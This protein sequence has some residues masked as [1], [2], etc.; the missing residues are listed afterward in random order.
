MSLLLVLLLAPPVSEDA[1][2]PVE[3]VKEAPTKVVLPEA[4][5]EPEVTKVVLPEAEPEAPEEKAPEEPAEVPA[6]EAAPEPP[7]PCPTYCDQ[8]SV[9]C[10]DVFLGNR[11]TC[12]ATCS[13]YPLDKVDIEA[14]HCRIYGQTSSL[15]IPQQPVE[16]KKKQVGPAQD[17]FF[18]DHPDLRKDRTVV[19]PGMGAV[20]LPPFQ[21]EEQPI[22]HA[23]KGGKLIGEGPLGRRIVL[24]P[25]DYTVH[26]GD[27]ADPVRVKVKVVEG[28]TTIVPEA[29]GGL[30]VDVV[31][32]R[33]VPFRGAYELIR[34]DTHD[35]V[36][37]GFGADALLGE[38]A[39]VW[40]VPPGIYKI[41]QSGGTY[42]DRTNFATVRV[43]SGEMQRFT[44]VMDPDT[45]EFEGAGLND[46]QE[47]DSGAWTF[48]GTI[49]GNVEFIRSELQAEE[50]S[51]QVSGFLD[52]SMRL[53]VGDHRWET[54]VDV[55]ESQ[56][57]NSTTQRFTNLNDRLFSHTIYTY[58]V[59][60]WFGPYVRA[61]FD[62]QILPREQT[63]DD[64][65]VI[66][67][68]EGNAQLTDR[69]LLAGFF[70]PM[71]FQEG[72]GGNVRVW[73]SREAEFYLRIGAGAFQLLPNR[74]RVLREVDGAPDR[75]VDVDADQL[76]GMESTAK[77]WARLF[78][79]V[80]LSTEFDSLLPFDR[81][82]AYI[83][84]WRSQLNLRLASFASLAYRFN[85]VRNEVLTLEDKILTEHNVQLRFS[86]TIF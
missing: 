85:A 71:S 54:R 42:R 25:G 76:E 61:R 9:K 27:G 11:A 18:D 52:L 86:W 41:I 37:L 1:P 12:L 10:P 58:E 13:L 65:R 72:T 84:N 67:D 83:F 66:I 36:G 45:G 82:D 3:P 28:R 16:L 26:L 34:M 15:P 75:L 8:M 81:P 43:L 70:S 79:W 4:P 20:F 55:E 50:L 57:R 51:A 63:F 73:R 39:K 68:T 30:Q 77:G 40:V 24:A 5:A 48:G 44:L 22:A 47:T 53:D 62:T 74:L 60:E 59:V 78:R 6:E 23:W 69:I 19:P 33:F 38:A 17:T 31:D 21:L 64:P 32:Q 46:E 80:T 56:T 14:L 49:G 29:W 7:D 2:P 35:V